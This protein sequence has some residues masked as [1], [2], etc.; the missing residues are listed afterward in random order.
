[1]EKGFLKIN[2]LREEIIFNVSRIMTITLIGLPSKTMCSYFCIENYFKNIVDDALVT[3]KN[4][5][6]RIFQDINQE[7][8]WGISQI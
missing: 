8:A 1:M 6:R 7:S 4:I 2:M 3:T 5:I